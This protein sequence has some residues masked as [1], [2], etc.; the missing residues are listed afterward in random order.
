MTQLR[1]VGCETFEQPVMDYRV[2]LDVFR[3]PVDLL[4]YLVRKHEI[5]VFDIPIADITEQ[6]LSYLELLKLIDIDV[7]G[8]FLVMAATLMEIKSRMLLP[9]APGEE[10]EEDP[11]SE[12]VRQLLEYKRFKDAA[13]LL[14]ELER[15]QADKF[16]RLSQD[17]PDA[18]LPQ[19]EAPLGHVELWDLVSAFGKLMRETLAG[20]A[21]SIVYDDT[22]IQEY[23]DELRE[24]LEDQGRL[25]FT[26]LF[27]ETVDKG[28]IVGL[29]LAVLELTRDKHIRAE[30]NEP[31]G[32][33][34]LF[35]ISPEERQA[36]LQ[37]EI[38][39]AAERARR[40][41]EEAARREA[42]EGARLRA[43]EA[44]KAQAESADPSGQPEP[45]RAP[46]ESSEGRHDIQLHAPDTTADPEVDANDQPGPTPSAVLS[47]ESDEQGPSPAV[48]LQDMPSERSTPTT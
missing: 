28:R 20:A 26:S 46:G 35:L 3:G 15:R 11:R 47:P 39:A 16:V 22:S 23:M 44:A 6:Y 14:E 13:G 41:A 5:D 29:F 8:D 45:D 21:R 33:I 18:D 10:D 32:E 4:L 2:D 43:A 9:R 7:A 36:I 42:E 30:Q 48:G 27:R 12:L 1:V 31:H 25:A 40:E 38:K 34:W 24:R 19:E 17:R 37:A